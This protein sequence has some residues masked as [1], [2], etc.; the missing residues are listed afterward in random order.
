MERFITGIPA[1]R[2]A[3]KAAELANKRKN[4]L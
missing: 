3:I 1:K 2:F 4:K